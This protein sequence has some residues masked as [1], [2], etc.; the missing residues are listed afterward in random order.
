MVKLNGEIGKLLKERE[1]NKRGQL[2][3]VSPA[4]RRAVYKRSK[5]IPGVI[6]R[7][8]KLELPEDLKEE[9]DLLFASNRRL[10][11]IGK[12]NWLIEA[13]RQK[14]KTEKPL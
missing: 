5:K 11:E 14:L 3:R 2:V 13:V 7:T 4:N 8:M 12:N 1:P 6:Y 9:V 10:Q